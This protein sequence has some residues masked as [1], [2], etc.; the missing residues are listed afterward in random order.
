MLCIST[1]E[2][3]IYL[4]IIA[5]VGDDKDPSITDGIKASLSHSYQIT[6]IKGSSISRCGSGYE[7]LLFEHDTLSELDISECIV[8]MK[9]GG[10]IPALPRFP[11][12]SI[13][14][15]DSQN[16]EQIGALHSLTSS[17]ITCGSGK[18]DTVSYTSFTEDGM[19]VSLNRSIKA[20]SGKQI[21]PLEIPIKFTK[22]PSSEKIYNCTALIALRL[23][24]DDYDSDIGFLF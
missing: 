10:K 23:V 15:A 5:L 20:F 16:S 8:L 17:V 12:R 6:H 22:E 1:A 7:I 13:V 11:E 14:I 4:T 19:V 2:R 21:Q 24:L 9:N 3:V 18:R